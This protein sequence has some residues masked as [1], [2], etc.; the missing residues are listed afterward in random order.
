MWAGAPTCNCWHAGLLRQLGEEPP[1]TRTVFLHHG[2]P[3]PALPANPAHAQMLKDHWLHWWRVQGAASLL[4]AVHKGCKVV[5]SVGLR[6]EALRQAGAAYHG[7]R[8]RQ[9]ACFLAHGNLWQRYL[10]PARWARQ[11]QGIFNSLGRM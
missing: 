9:G 3:A 11:G 2:V 8:R 10:P 1:H 4:T 5:G 6:V 7:Q